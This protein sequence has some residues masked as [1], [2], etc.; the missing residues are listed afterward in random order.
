MQ[1]MAHIAHIRMFGC[2]HMPNEKRDKLDVKG[3]KYLFFGYSEK[4]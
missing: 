3:T 1:W 4:Q 2:M